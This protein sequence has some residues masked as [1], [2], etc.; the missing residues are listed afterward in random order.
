M[1]DATISHEVVRYELKSLP[2]GWVELKQLPYYDM[3]HR[4]DKGSQASME[5]Q[6][7]GRKRGQ[8]QTAK[9]VID[10]L[11]TWERD[12]MFKSCI[13]N[14]NLTDKSGKDLD[15]NNPMALHSLRPEVGLEIEQLIDELNSEGVEFGENFPKVVTSSL[16]PAP[17]V[18][19]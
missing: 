17:A 13:V 7:E 12:Y 9:M 2:E 3:L 4:R 5:Q 16:E 8:P 19:T 10:T 18:E 15:F 14:H 11:Q 1:P 6:V